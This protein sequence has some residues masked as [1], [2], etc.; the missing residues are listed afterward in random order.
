MTKR[1]AWLA[2]LF[3]ALLIAAAGIYRIPAVNDRLAWRLDALQ[4]D[5]QYALSPPEE[6]VFI[7]Q[8]QEKLFTLTAVSSPT[9]PPATAT[10]TEATV[11]QQAT[12]RPLPSN[13][14]TQMP[15]P[16]PESVSLTGVRHE[17]QTWNNCGPT[18]LSM[19]LS[20]WGWPGNQAASAAYLKP[21]P[22]DKNVMPSEMAGFIEMQTEFN[23]LVRVGGNIEV[24]KRLVSAGIP[25]ILEKGFEG[26]NFE[27]WM[28]H[29]VTVTGY[30]D[31]LGQFTTQDSFLGP[32]VQV[33]YAVIETFWRAFNF[34]YI[35]VYPQ[36]R[37]VEIRTLLGPQYEEEASVRLALDLAS[38]EIYTLAGRDQFF[39]WFNRGTN[40]VAL[41]DYAGAAAAYDAA[42][43]LYAALP[44]EERPWRMMWYQTGPYWAYYYTARYNDVIGL[45][46]T[47][48]DAMSEPVLEESYY[49][50]A[51]AR[52]ALGD[53][54]G[55]IKDL[56]ISLE[57]H[58]EFSPSMEQ[59]ERLGV[60]D[61]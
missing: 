56:Q 30:D 3:A 36:D 15:T 35:V 1:L 17:Y 44:E 2:L 19:A 46:T 59:L 58:P 8:Q 39:A 50:R 34:T 49:W 53:V 23:A 6:A 24:V 52:E 18:N 28:G 7:P 57:H 37:E 25:V 26:P 12:D 20:F 29:Y 43:D 40:L 54:D 16:L 48:L 41:Q 32:D 51:L 4:A 55:A 22:R 31:A 11:G 47:T 13:T 10:P 60:V 21:N 27:G 42:F 5:I 38:Q 14:A 61:P 33:D 45:A 9:A